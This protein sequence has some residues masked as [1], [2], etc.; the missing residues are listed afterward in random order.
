MSEVLTDLSSP[1]IAPAIE[2]NLFRYLE[3]CGRSPSVE[4]H[5]SP[6]VTWLITGIQHPFTNAV[7]RARFE[8][9]GLDR[10]I[11][12]VLE[13]FEDRNA[14]FS[15]WVGPD[16]K[17]A[18][19]GARLEAHGLSYSE[20]VRGMA[21]DLAGLVDGLQMPPRL[22]VLPVSSDEILEQWV[23][24]AVA[25]FGLPRSSGQACF[26]LF[27]GLGYRLPLRCY[28]GLLGNRPVAVSQLFLASGVAGV[29]WVATVPEARRRGF[30]SAVTLAALADAYR[31]GYRIGILHPSELGLRVYRR[32]G[33]RQHCRLR[34]A[35]WRGEGT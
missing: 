30:G 19:L 22:S 16:S 26:D 6:G 10:A 13:H 32:L 14:P 1:A 11:K 8:P 27:A 31:S 4:F 33:F 9:A 5:D 28:S 15:W 12:S 18:D 35:V 24:T 25:G 7:I 2:A 23:E 29:Y 17:P 20:Q 34:C 3:Y 21:A